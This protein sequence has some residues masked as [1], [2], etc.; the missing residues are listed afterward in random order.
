MKHAYLILAHNEFELLQILVSRLDDFR[1][2][3]YVHIDCK[4]KVLPAIYVEKSK[5]YTLP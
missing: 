5:L 1:N 4:V 2:D 3:I